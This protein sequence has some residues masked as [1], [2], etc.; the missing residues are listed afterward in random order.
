M[1]EKKGEMIKNRQTVIEKG[2]LSKY[3]DKEEEEER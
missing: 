1:R 2:I 3:V